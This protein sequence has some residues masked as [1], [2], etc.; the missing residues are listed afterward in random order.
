MPPGSITIIP[1][2]VFLGSKLPF[3]DDASAC[4]WNRYPGCKTYLS[5]QTDTLNLFSS[6]DTST[7]VVKQTLGPLSESDRL[8][9]LTLFEAFV[10]R[11]TFSL[12]QMIMAV[13][14]RAFAAPPIGASPALTHLGRSIDMFAATLAF[15]VEIITIEEDIDTLVAAVEAQS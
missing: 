3:S 11:I 9:I 12:N 10:A 7:T 14:E 13:K 5:I 1:A 15:I 2:L 8:T 6:I 4:D